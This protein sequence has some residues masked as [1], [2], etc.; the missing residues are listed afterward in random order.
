MSYTVTCFIPLIAEWC[1]EHYITFA[2][3]TIIKIWTACE[4][5]LGK[6]CHGCWYIGRDE[7]SIMQIRPNRENKPTGGKIYY[8]LGD[9]IFEWGNSV[10]IIQRHV[11]RSRPITFRV[12]T[13]VRNINIYI[14]IYQY[15][16]LSCQL[17]KKLLHSAFMKGKKHS[18][19]T[20]NVLSFRWRTPTTSPWP[21]A[22]G[23]ATGSRYIDRG[24]R[25]RTHH[26]HVYIVQ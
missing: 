18:I 24:S 10:E 4:G 7:V 1:L 13:L 25:S 22:N 20:L 23:I 14:Y 16:F 19:I 21:S 2:T 6:Y 15:L 26:I 17:T 8:R 5:C 12:L 3:I 9:N 11:T